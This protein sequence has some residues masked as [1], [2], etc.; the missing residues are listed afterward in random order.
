M[1]KNKKIVA[2]IPARG[3]SKAIPNK[4]IIPICGK[5]LMFYAIQAGLTSKYIDDIY[6]SS[7]S[8]A[9]LR[10]AKRHKAGCIKRPAK[11]A[12]DD[13]KTIDAVKHAINY[14]AKT[15]REYDYIV[16]LQP[17]SPLR[18]SEDIDLAIEQI[19][20]DKND[21]LISVTRSHVPP[22][23]L[24]RVKSGNNLYF[25]DDKFFNDIRRQALPDYYAFNGAVYI[26]K[27]SVVL[28]NYAYPY[29]SGKTSAYIMPAHRSVDV[30][31]FEDL[32]TCELILKNIKSYDSY[33]KDKK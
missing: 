28:G 20:K 11:L 23:L 21:I 8:D 18:K 12:T 14:L 5:P 7:D 33:N 32:L 22:N 26:Y 10:I 19:F 25:H 1:Y 3:G 9:I 15:G 2:I 30:D 6:V 16:L 4:N 31:S 17:T 13:A 27:K 29:I 24:I